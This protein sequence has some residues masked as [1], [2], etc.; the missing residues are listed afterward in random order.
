MKGL[1]IIGTSLA[2]CGFL[3]LS[4][5]HLTE[6]FIFGLF[7]C[8]CLIP[9]FYKNDLLPLLA[10]QAFFLCVNINGIINNIGF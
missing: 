6:G 9:V 1:E 7:S 3:L 2:A 5:N 8:F 10:L 4:E